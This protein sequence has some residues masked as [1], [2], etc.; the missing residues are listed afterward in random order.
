MKTG[1][2]DTMKSEGGLITVD[3][4][5]Y[6]TDTPSSKYPHMDQVQNEG[7]PM[8]EYG[9]GTAVPPENGAPGAGMEPAPG[10]GGMPQDGMGQN[11]Y[12]QNRQ[13]DGAGN[14][15]PSPGDGSGN[16]G[17]GE[18]TPPASGDI[19]SIEAQ[20]IDL[21]NKEREKNGLPALQSS[22][23]VSD[24]AR[25]KSKDMEE[26][27]Y[28]SHT[29]PTYGSPFDMMRDFGVQYETAGENIAMGQKS[30]EEVVKAWME[31]EGH[32]KNIL[33]GTYTEIGVGYNAEGQYWT[34]M[35]ISK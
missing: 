20:V 14:G 5:P 18:K 25:E 27:D 32:R 23:Q 7:A 21:T 6:S 34:Q 2:K 11:G 22:K 10:Q 4:K 30:P 19:T 35:F 3:R 31:S 1:T 24:V 29:S 15:A 16:S 8:Y 28:F 17:S 12:G 9:P 33:N 13:Q 26:K